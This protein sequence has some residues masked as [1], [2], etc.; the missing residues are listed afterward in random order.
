MQWLL[1]ANA[2]LLLTFLT[3]ANT[4]GA[5]ICNGHRLACIGLC[6]HHTITTIELLPRRQ[7]ILLL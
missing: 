3:L 6:N 4:V 2:A 5:V 1:A 7:G